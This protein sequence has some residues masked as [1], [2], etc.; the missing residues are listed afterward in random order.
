MVK[1]PF[2]IK[3]FSFDRLKKAIA[4]LLL[5]NLLSSGRKFVSDT[6]D[7]CHPT[8]LTFYIPLCP[9]LSFVITVDFNCFLISS[10][11]IFMFQSV[12]NVFIL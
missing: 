6:R 1:V 4:F 10:R 7:T 3:N 5:S 11:A 8:T 9:L 12:W 2:K